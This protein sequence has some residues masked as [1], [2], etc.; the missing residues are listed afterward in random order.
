MVRVCLEVSVWQ[1][2]TPHRLSR[3]AGFFS[4]DDST[5]DGKVAIPPLFP[6]IIAWKCPPINDFVIQ[7]LRLIGFDSE[8]PDLVAARFQ[9]FNQPIPAHQMQRT[10]CNKMGDAAG[11]IALDSLHH[12]RMPLAEQYIV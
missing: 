9:H 5:L 11:Q 12:G 4:S 10:D 1:Y 2:I 7:M 8:L 3:D 6:D